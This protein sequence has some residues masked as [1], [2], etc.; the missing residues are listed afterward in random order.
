MAEPTEFMM[1]ARASCSDGFCGEVRR[2]IIDPATETIT[3]LVIDPGHRGQPA[4]LVPLHLVDTAAGE[5]RLR[6][7]LT[8]FGELDS[9]K[10]TEVIEHMGSPGG[11]LT[12]MGVGT[13]RQHKRVRTFATDAVPVGEAEV[14]S[15]EPV[16][17]VDGEIGRVHG[18]LVNPDDQQVTH[19]LLG[20]G[21]LWG[22]KEV[23]IPLSAVAG[24]ED[25]IRLN[26]TKKQVEDLPPVD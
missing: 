2:V 24:T 15:G 1:G 21:H 12:G 11:P 25:G 7:S 4:R 20:E 9:A 6:C 10:D 17:A 19:V 22:R 5:V 8:E 18:F 23:A 16:H 13:V 26:I 3:H 14:S